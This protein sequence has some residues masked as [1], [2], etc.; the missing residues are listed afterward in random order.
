MNDTDTCLQEIKDRALAFTKERDWEQF[1]SP[2]NLS[3]AISAEAAE[4]M[5]HFLWQ[6]PEQSREDAC[7]EK[8]Q[9]K[10]KEELA[11]IFLFAIQFANMTGI[12]ISAA[13]EAKIK[14]NGEKY[15]VEKARGRSDKYTDL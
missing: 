12:D 7:S 6:T 15:P 14:R 3:M 2:K 4:L 11:D 9:A 8:L 10:V 5:E 1:H 13:I